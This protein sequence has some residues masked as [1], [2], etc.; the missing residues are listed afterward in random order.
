[1]LKLSRAFDDATQVLICDVIYWQSKD[2]LILL[3]G[4]ADNQNFFAPRPLPN[5]TY[6]RLFSTVQLHICEFIWFANRQCW[7]HTYPLSFCHIKNDRFRP[8]VVVVRW[9]A[10]LPST[11][12]IRVRI[13]QSL[14]F[15][16]CNCLIRTKINKRGQGWPIFEKWWSSG[17]LV[18]LLR[19]W[20][21]VR[22]HL[23]ST[24]LIL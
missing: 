9:P 19:R 3:K 22:V 17:Q 8:V 13:Q 2:R 5:I 11:T 15:L 4:L 6:L 7:L 21:R 23:K 10:C 24:V 16:F 12:M 1:M 18:C 20:I 14:Q